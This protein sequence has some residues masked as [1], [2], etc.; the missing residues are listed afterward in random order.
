MIVNKILCFIGGLHNDNKYLVVILDLF[1]KIIGA[2]AQ[3]N[4]INFI[5]QFNQRISSYFQLANNLSFVGAIYC[6]LVQII[7]Y[8]CNFA[9]IS[10]ILPFISAFFFGYLQ[11]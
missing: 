9:F 6:L 1:I 5:L 11:I 4:G 7:V 3:I 2:N 10:V 8:W